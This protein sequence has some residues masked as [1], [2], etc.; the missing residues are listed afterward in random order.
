MG[1]WDVMAP[2][3]QVV[4]GSSDNDDRFSLELGKLPGLKR[5]GGS[6]RVP[7]NAMRVVAKLCD[8]LSVPVRHAG[9]ETPLRRPW[10]WASIL[11]KLRAEG[12][13]REWVLDGFLTQYQMDAITFG[14]PKMGVHFWHATGAG[15]TL[16]GIVTALSEPGSI[17]VV[18]KAA[19]RLQFAREIERFTTLRAYVVRPDTQR[20]K[21]RT[22]AG[23]TWLDFFR[24]RMPALGK[25]ALVSEE[26]Q[27][28]KAQHG[29]LTRT[30][31]T[32]EDYV[33][34]CEA[35]HRRPSVVV[36]WEAL[37][38]NLGL[39]ATLEPT[40]LLV[41]EL[42]QGSGSKRWEVLPL[43]DLPRDAKESRAQLRK[44]KKEADSLGGFLK[45]DEEGRKMIVPIM[46]RAAAA[47]Q[48]ARSVSKRIGTTA[49]PV[50]DRVR[51][52]W[53]QLDIIEPNAWGNAT[54]WMNRHCDRKPG[55]YGGY[56]TRG[57]S[58]LDE[59]KVR[60][61][62]TA[63]IL[64]YHETH[65]HLPPKRRQSYYIAPEDQC[66][67]S[68]GF[69]KERKE[70]AKRGATAVMEVALAEAASR[71]RKAVLG[72]VEDHLG[73]NQKVVVFTGRRRDCEAL[74]KSV[75]SLKSVKGNKETPPIM[76]WVAH[77][78]DSDKLRDQIVQD[79]MAHPGP[80]VM[81]GTGHAFGESL[82]MDTADAVL[83]VMLPLS[84]GQL[85]QWEGRFSRASSKK[86][87]LIYYVICE[88][89]ADEHMAAIL[90]DK[91]PAVEK[92]VEDKELAEAEGVLAGYDPNE[93]DEEFA[94]S[95][96]SSLDF[97]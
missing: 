81:V 58:N 35:A 30:E 29:V 50:R 27:A 83:F 33:E 86:P 22:V 8:S 21:T 20:K 1:K 73:S 78:G 4:F 62:Q 97:G 69:S 38:G 74:G 26:W 90:I 40:V 18:T 82:N 5:R 88:D 91:L 11:A 72:L 65:A 85:R 24:K 76:S 32:L 28:L 45:T 56:D 87:V 64:S 66:R 53:A 80:C 71:K 46:N 39:V 89:T 6:W 3:A 14:W 75:R 79:F 60:L 23:Q 52:L 96:L 84:P 36:A 93:T 92:I 48:V 61:E 63:H 12:E 49:T 37:V 57:S 67:P 43:S 68:S 10:E 16:T 34:A 55:L 31:G 42:H 9:W 47:A 25:A 59:L 95:I 7:A 51:N 41:D 77:G 70:A 17:L 15:K 19:A 54:S 2:H 44:E 94:K 13:V